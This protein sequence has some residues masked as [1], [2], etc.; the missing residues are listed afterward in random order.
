LKV[1]PPVHVITG[2]R[3]DILD[4]GFDLLRRDAPEL[5]TMGAAARAGISRQGR[6]PHFAT[7]SELVLAIVD[8]SNERLGLPSTTPTSPARWLSAV[9]GSTAS[10]RVVDAL[11]RDRELRR[12]LSRDGARTLLYA[13]TLPDPVIACLEA[14]D[15]EPGAARLLRRALEAASASRPIPFRVDAR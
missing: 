1:A 12:G 11:A 9:D 4:A 8:Y 5:L 2:T 7:R 3:W 10:A 6:Y 14:E 15:G 13:M